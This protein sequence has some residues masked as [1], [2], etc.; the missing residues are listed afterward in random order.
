MWSDTILP[1]N[2]VRVLLNEWQQNRMSSTYRLLQVASNDDQT[3]SA[4]KRNDTSD[5]NFWLRACGAYNSESRI[6][7]LS[8]KSPMIVRTQLET[9][10]VAKRYAF[11]VNMIQTWCIHKHNFNLAPQCTGVNVSAMCE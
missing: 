10:F 4:V 5:H 2:N 1:K 6:G 7:T 8:W 11:P 3:S 9:G